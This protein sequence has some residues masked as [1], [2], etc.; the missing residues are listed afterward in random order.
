MD[1]NGCKREMC[2][3]KIHSMSQWRRAMLNKKKELIAAGIS[4]FEFHPEYVRI[5]QCK[6]DEYLD[7]DQCKSMFN[8]SR[9]SSSRKSPSRKSPTGKSPKKK[10][11]IGMRYNKKNG[12]CEGSIKERCR[13]GTRRNKKTGE[14]E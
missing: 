9:K 8:T 11:S 4:Q 13:K 2:D 10:C 3:Q 14:C 6:E 7:E 1:K 5:A 12:L